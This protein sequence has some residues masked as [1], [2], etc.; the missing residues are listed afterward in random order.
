MVK[1]EYVDENT[2]ETTE[3]HFDDFHYMLAE[4]IQKLLFD[5]LVTD[6]PLSA[7]VSSIFS[8]ETGK[9]LKIGIAEER[10]EFKD[11][12]EYWAIT[13]EKIKR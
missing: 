4:Q 10:Q 8:D 12:D 11:R 9:K 2:F 7:D 5:K 6:S 3:H 13:I 1:I